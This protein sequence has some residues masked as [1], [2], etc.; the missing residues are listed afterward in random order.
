MPIPQ[1]AL[2]VV[3]SEDL[4][5]DQGYSAKSSYKPDSDD[6]KNYAHI[7]SKNTNCLSFLLIYDI[8]Q[9]LK[10]FWNWSRQDL[11]V[12]IVIIVSHS[13]FLLL[14]APARN[15]LLVQTGA[16][17]NNRRRANG[18]RQKEKNNQKNITPYLWGYSQMGFAVS[19]STCC[20][21]WVKVISF[22]TNVIP[23][24]LLR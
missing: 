23:V 18:K 13:C 9:D 15:P 17:S 20:A 1:Y 10:S 6:S 2:V 22:H 12:I 14:V 7:I 8:C 5:L 19:H 11:K 3:D 24:S 16:S 21:F 4:Y